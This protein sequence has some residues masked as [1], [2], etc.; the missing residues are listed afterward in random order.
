M[1]GGINIGSIHRSATFGEGSLDGLPLNTSLQN[2]PSKHLSEE[3]IEA[4]KHFLDS[5]GRD[6]QLDQSSQTK[7]V[8]FLRVEIDYLKKE[9]RQLREISGTKE[10]ENRLHQAQATEIQNRLLKDVASKQDLIGQLKKQLEVKNSQIKDEKEKNHKLELLLTTISEQLK[11]NEKETN[12]YKL[13]L[14]E[15]EE[16][17]VKD[18]DEISRLVNII[19]RET[20]EMDSLKK[21][22]EKAEQAYKDNDAILKKKLDYALKTFAEYLSYNSTLQSQ[23]FEKDNRIK[24]LEKLHEQE[25]EDSQNL[26][27]KYKAKVE[28][29]KAKLNTTSQD[30]PES[31]QDVKN[32]TEDLR[33]RL[34]QADQN[35]I[36]QKEMFENKINL[37]NQELEEKIAFL[38][39]SASSQDN[40][41]VGNLSKVG[42][43]PLNTLNIPLLSQCILKNQT[44]TTIDSSKETVLSIEPELR[45]SEK[46]T[47]EEIAERSESQPKSISRFKLLFHNLVDQMA[48]LPYSPENNK[49]EKELMRRESE[50][51]TP[52]FCTQKKFRSKPKNTGSSK[53]HLRSE[54]IR[55]FSS[56]QPHMDFSF[57]SSYHYKNEG[58]QH[59]SE[60]KSEQNQQVYSVE[61]VKSEV[62]KIFVALNSQFDFVIQTILQKLTDME[63]IFVRLM[64]IASL[65]EKR[66]DLIKT[67]EAENSRLTK[68]LRVFKIKYDDQKNISVHQ[69]TVIENLNKRKNN[70]FSKREEHYIK[71]LTDLTNEIKILKSGGI[72][73]V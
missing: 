59:S 61:F 29:L 55:L 18:K 54:N 17:S 56:S 41:E 49:H 22:N 31:I 26:K 25:K 52:A 67:Y 24:V 39:K 12:T 64:N 30:N 45:D 70:D 48:K 5:K 72:S 19:D 44:E 6:L 7:E 1:K 40:R 66:E 15:H 3:E 69:Q 47:Q 27:T 38:H 42:A 13:M 9:N 4:L 21:L 37:L 65:Q 71:L 8:Y 16:K 43:I 20:R 23:V 68:Q 60:Q 35:L 46:R 34:Q 28:K 53:I 2:T 11:N 50:D 36:D 10:K 57:L 73:D 62:S 51:D 32:E 63:H 58:A 14:I 33:K